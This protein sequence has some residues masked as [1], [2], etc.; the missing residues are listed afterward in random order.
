M[1][2]FVIAAA[3]WA[4]FAFGNITH[5]QPGL[6]GG[7]ERM[8]AKGPGRPPLPM[9]QPAPGGLRPVNAWQGKVV[10][11]QYNE[12]SVFDGFY[13]LNGSDSLLITFPPHLGKQIAG[14]AKVGAHVN[15]TGTA[16]STPFGATGVRLVSINNA[17]IDDSPRQ[18][19]PQTE[20]FVEQK[21]KISS[22]RM[23]RDG[24]VNGLLLDNKTL[25]KLPPHMIM[26]LGNALQ[27]GTPIAYSGNQKNAA[28]GEISQDNLTIVHANTLTINGQQ[29]LLR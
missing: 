7:P 20:K 14:A 22:L 4:A 6:P 25:L 27:P 26:Q 28:D 15:L 10:K 17:T 12:D 16:E 23:G 1:R 13:L 3:M 21:G 11:W 5:A 9:G 2:A 24:M 19:M 18:E 29:Y 8:A